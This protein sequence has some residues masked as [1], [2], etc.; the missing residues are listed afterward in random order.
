MKQQRSILILIVVPGLVSLIV[1]LIVLRVWDSRSGDEQVVVLPT[2]SATSQIPPLAEG[3]EPGDVV[4]E[5]PSDDGADGSVDSEG[6]PDGD[7]VEPT[8]DPGCEN[9]LHVV[10]AGEVLGSIAEEYGLTIRDIVEL[11]LIHI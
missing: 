4:A 3:V 6:G 9:P 11:S 10:A 5:A 8:I 2:T 7:A 1:T